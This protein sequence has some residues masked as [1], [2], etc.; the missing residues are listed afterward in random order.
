MLERRE[1]ELGSAALQSHWDR[2]R[3]NLRKRQR[4]PITKNPIEWGSGVE[5]GPV[6]RSRAFTAGVWQ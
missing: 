6:H 4:K 2:P 3:V 5:E 1:P